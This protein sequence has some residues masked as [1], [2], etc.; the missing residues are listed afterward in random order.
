MTKCFDD[1]HHA[2]QKPCGILQ[3]I[4]FSSPSKSHLFYSSQISNTAF[5]SLRLCWW[6]CFGFTEKF[7]NNQK[8]TSTSSTADLHSSVPKFLCNLPFLDMNERCPPIF[9]VYLVSSA[10]AEM[11]FMSNQPPL[12]FLFS[13]ILDASVCL[14]LGLV[15]K[16]T[17]MLSS[18]WGESLNPAFLLRYYTFFL[19]QQKNLLK[20]PTLP[21][22]VFCPPVSTG[23][24]PGQWSYPPLQETTFVKAPP[25][26]SPCLFR[27]TEQQ[28][29]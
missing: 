25:I 23:A 15:H 1:L 21:A 6:P 28:H 13:Y 16:C 29:E 2:A 9:I 19:P 10:S 5:L 8:R 26:T 3:A 20:M 14:L 4:P 7:E 17:D 18:W 12:S 22:S 24:T 11:C 27:V